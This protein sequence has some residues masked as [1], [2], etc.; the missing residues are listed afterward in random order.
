MAA[1]FILPLAACMAHDLA[2]GKAY[3]L[4]RLLERNFSVPAGFCL[5]TRF[6]E[7]ALDDGGFDSDGWWG[8]LAEAQPQESAGILTECRAAILSLAVPPPMQRLVRDAV[9]DLSTGP[10]PL[11]AVRSSATNEDRA[12][13]SFAGL[14]HSELGINADEWWPSVRRCWASLWSERVWTYS[15]RLGLPRRPPKMAVIIQHAIPARASGVGYSA[16]VFTDRRDHVVLNAVPGLGAPFVNGLVTPDHYVIRTVKD[17]APVVLTRTIA[18]KFAIARLGQTGLVEKR[19]EDSRVSAGP[20]LTD[21]EACELAGEVKR[22]EQALGHP[23]DVEWA[24]EDSRVWILQARPITVATGP[25]PLTNRA[26]TWSRANFKE[27]LPELPSPLGLSFLER[28]MEHNMVR[29]YRDLGCLVPPNVDPVRVVRGRPYINVTLFQSFTAQL[30]G[31]PSLLA[32]HMGGEVGFLPMDVPPLSLLR[33]I[34][35]GLRLLSRMR[36]ALRGAPSWF[37]E[38]KRMRDEH[39][40]E[41]VQRLTMQEVVDRLKRLGARLE[42]MDMTFAIVAGVA[43][44]LEVLHLLLP[45]WIGDD[46]RSLLNGALQ[47]QGNVISAGQILRMAELAQAVHKE[48]GVSRF[49][50]S[51]PFEPGSFRKALDGTAF[52]G[53]FEQYLADYG[54]RGIGESDIMSPSFADRPELL[55]RLVRELI[56]QESCVGP[57]AIVRRQETA[58]QN[59]LNEVRRRFGLHKLRWIVFLW[60]YRRLCRFLALREANRHHLMYFSSG[61]R[62]LV[63][64]LGGLMLERALVSTPDD[65]FFMSMEEQVGLLH[66]PDRDWKAVIAERRKDRDRHAEFNV[67]DTIPG[68]S[69]GRPDTDP[70]SGTDSVAIFRGVPVS[71]GS[72]A[73]PVRLVRGAEDL[74]LVRHGDIVVAPVIDPG[75]APVMGIA[76]GLIAE[77]GGTLSHGAIIAREFG[78]PTL[79]NLSGI[80]NVLHDGELVLLDAA[81]GEIR[82]LGA[83]QR[84]PRRGSL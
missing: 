32:E 54:H 17:G 40:P 67:P 42:E 80:M 10:S 21:R 72:A 20:T 18:R 55:L 15:R 65:V 22:I 47:G 11:V 16:D 3:G 28:F 64:R 9:Q 24:L 53:L 75:M 74:H 29:H 81:K 26:C 69:G 84:E 7:A 63:R 77:M 50:L 2:G 33:R 23:V 6:Y 5:T 31:N 39:R 51:A 58:R 46:W 48:P 52:L 49:F 38:L 66:H 19:I 45:R 43:Q 35:A 56:G 27:T 1:S 25:S 83:D 4:A 57:D 71:T 44:S 60:W 82:R 73:G 37:D 79:V 70:V 76:G 8:R 41:C 59:A 61:V 36:Q 34:R 78:L 12:G 62:N 14:Y 13:A 30:G 68:S